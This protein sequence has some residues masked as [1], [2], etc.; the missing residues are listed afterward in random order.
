MHL[1]GQCDLADDMP[2]PASLS[3]RTVAPRGQGS[4]PRTAGLP[5]A[6]AP[7]AVQP[8]QLPQR[9]EQAHAGRDGSRF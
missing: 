2:A 1:I 3:T 8:I 5:A 4:D 6:R 9:L 7:S